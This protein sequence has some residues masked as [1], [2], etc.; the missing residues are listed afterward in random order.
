VFSRIVP[1]ES[2]PLADLVEPEF[3]SL[4]APVGEGPFHIKGTALRG[5]LEFY[6]QLPGGLARIR[7]AI[8]NARLL[9]YFDE[10]V[11]AGTWYDVF[12]SVAIDFA[13]ARAHRKAPAD[14]LTES[15]VMQARAMLRGVYKTMLSLFTPG[16]MAWSLP[17][18]SSTFFDFAE[19]T[20]V[21]RGPHHYSGEFSGVPMVLAGWW[22]RVS[23]DFGVEAMRIRGVPGARYDWSVPREAGMRH[24]MR[25]CRTTITFSWDD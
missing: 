25:V 7:D 5:A 3:E 22:Q 10:P 17:R 2:M 21:E 23:G 11:L 14:W 9:R 6:A 16:A 20:T 13:A 24:G 15:T 8:T 19:M 1:A 18:V 12:V 4:P